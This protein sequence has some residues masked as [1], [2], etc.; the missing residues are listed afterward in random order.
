M[1]LSLIIICDNNSLWQRYIVA[2]ILELKHESKMKK[3]E[4]Q[5][6]YRLEIERKSCIKPEHWTEEDEKNLTRLRK[7]SKGG[8]LSW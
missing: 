5:D 1:I 7:E 4:F 6:L 3:Y 8:Y 2:T